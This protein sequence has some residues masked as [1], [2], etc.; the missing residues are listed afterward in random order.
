MLKRIFLL[1]VSAILLMLSCYN[2][3]AQ[4]IGEGDTLWYKSLGP[5][6][7][8]QVQFSTDGMKLGVFIERNL[9][10][11]LIVYEALTGKQLWKFDLP[12]FA[13]NFQFSIDGNLVY[14]FTPS[15]KAV[16]GYNSQTGE[17]V[18]TNKYENEEN[19]TYWYLYL[20]KNPNRFMITNPL[21]SC[22][23]FDKIEKKLLIEKLS[24]RNTRMYACPY[25]DYF[26]KAEGY[27]INKV[28]KV[29]ISLWNVNTLE[30]VALLEEI[31]ASLEDGSDIKISYN[32]KYAATNFGTTA[33]KIWD[34]ENKKLFKVYSPTINKPGAQMGLAFAH[35]EPIIVNTG[36]YFYE[37]SG[38]ATTITNYLNDKRA[39]FYDKNTYF[40]YI[41]IDKSD[42]YLAFDGGYNLVVI[43]LNKD[44]VPVEEIKNEKIKTLYPNPA[45]GTISILIPDNFGIIERTEI[46]DNFGSII[47][48]LDS[49]N[50]KLNGNNLTLNVSDL[51][52]G[53]YFLRIS[54]VAN[55]I[56]YKLI[57][58]R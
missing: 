16:F 38:Y 15:E 1:I 30:S 31:D 43:K 36:G 23:I 35:N 34:L 52:N 50:N 13:Q 6:E 27:I 9:T 2:T 45:T 17:L 58:K 28:S 11:N 56:T 48:L 55:S 22:A 12:Y 41:D 37:F 14:I 46:I 21:G 8:K 26:I 19:A 25:S 49:K 4:L 24:N 40:H 51:Q 44:A 3:Q 54:N 33:L 20:T 39:I 53:S 57:V 29:N 18:E 10:R 32:G 47:R 42:K 7:V 5:N